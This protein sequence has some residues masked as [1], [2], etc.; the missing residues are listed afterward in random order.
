MEENIK[1]R[2]S[3]ILDL[4]DLAKIFSSLGLIIQNTKEYLN[5]DLKNDEGFLTDGVAM[6]VA[7]VSAMTK[8]RRKQEDFPSQSRMKQL[9]ACWIERINTLR[10]LLS[11][12]NEL[13]WKNTEA[14][15]KII[16][17]YIAGTT[18]EVSDPNLISNSMLMTRQQFE[19]QVETLKKS[20]ARKI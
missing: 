2:M 11:Q 1:K 10:G 9:K 18:I 3:L 5:A 15:S 19:E 13:S 14:Y 20:S 7:K 17:L 16:G 8:Q 6:F 4:W 12:L